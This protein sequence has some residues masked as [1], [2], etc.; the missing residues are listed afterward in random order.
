MTDLLSAMREFRVL[1][2]RRATALLPAPELARWTELRTLLGNRA[3]L[4]VPPPEGTSAGPAGHPPTAAGVPPLIDAG[5]LEEVGPPPAPSTPT[6]LT[7]PLGTPGSRPP[8]Q[9]L[10]VPQPFTPPPP[11]AAP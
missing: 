8:S 5:D 9:P 7:V 1:E 11:V 4:V 3:R 2:E 10:A 6:V